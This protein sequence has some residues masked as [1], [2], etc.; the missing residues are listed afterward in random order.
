MKPITIVAATALALLP[1][2]GCSREGDAAAAP[3]PATASAPDAAGDKAP[4]IDAAYLAGPWCYLHYEAGGERSDENIDYVFSGD[5]TLLYQNNAGSALDRQGSWTLE[6]DGLSIGPAI[7]VIS[8]RIQSVEAD[9]FVLG[10][11]YTRMVF[12]RGACPAEVAS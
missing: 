12:Q 6:G 5:G 3:A 2:T 7:W 9:R 10:N 8:K 11:K 4:T 1:A